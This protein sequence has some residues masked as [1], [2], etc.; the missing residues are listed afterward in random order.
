MYASA[1]SSRS[2]PGASSHSRGRTPPPPR[3]RTIAELAD[4]ARDD[5][6]DPSQTVKHWLVVADH[7]RRKG[8]ANVESRDL[9][10]GFIQY[11]RAATIVLEKLPG[12]QDYQTTLN[13]MQ[14]HNLGL[15]S[16]HFACAF[17][18]SVPRPMLNLYFYRS[19]SISD[20]PISSTSH[21]CYYV[22]LSAT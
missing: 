18:L 2:S 7:A 6:W 22:C 15:V 10:N 11:A 19:A 3:P 16:S 9:E 12:H 21:A 8:K 20:Y 4:C 5:G 14:R 17:R 1:H 13:A